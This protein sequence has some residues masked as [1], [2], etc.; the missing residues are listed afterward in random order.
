M[1][2][3]EGNLRLKRQ[4][5]QAKGQKGNKKKKKKSRNFFFLF[6]LVQLISGCCRPLGGGRTRVA[7]RSRPLSGLLARPSAACASPFSTGNTKPFLTVGSSSREWQSRSRLWQL[8]IGP[9]GDNNSAPGGHPS[10]AVAV[11]AQITVGCVSPQTVSVIVSTGCSRCVQ[12]VSMR[13]RVLLAVT[14]HS[15]RHVVNGRNYSASLFL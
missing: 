6:P 14:S 15:T 1:I 5:K 4:M 11:G 3:E 2:N 10:L 7:H 12:C 9:L 8:S 13:L